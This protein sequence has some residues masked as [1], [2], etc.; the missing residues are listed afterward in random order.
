VAIKIVQAEAVA[1]IGT[2][3]LLTELGHSAGLTHPNILPML[4][5]GIEAGHPYL[6]LPFVRGGS[7]RHRLERHVRLPL[8]EAIPLLEGVA[9]GLNYAHERQV[10]H[11]D[12]KPENILVDDGHAYLMDFGI[13]RR[14][15]AEADEWAELRRSI[16][17]TAGTPAYVSPEQAAGDAVDQRSDIYSLACVAYE[18]LSGR[19]PFEGTTTQEV[20][21]RRFRSPAPPLRDTAPEVPEAVAD[22]IA[23]AMALSPDRRPDSATA[24]ITELRTAASARS[25]IATTPRSR[26]RAHSCACA[27]GSASPVRHASASH[28]LE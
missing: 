28:S 5:A 27:A 4:D 11:C 24:F 13:A 22:V 15:H 6:V 16:G 8:D 2:E 23:R 18:M 7:L 14:L 25:R 10:L 19:T 1:G 21:S 26:P 9:R 17:Y 3:Q 12:V 20:V